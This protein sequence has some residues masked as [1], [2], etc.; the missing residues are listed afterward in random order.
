MPHRGDGNGPL[1]R[2]WTIRAGW[3]REG[4]RALDPGLVAGRKGPACQHADRQGLPRGNSVSGVCCAF[5]PGILRRTPATVLA[6]QQSPRLKPAEYDGI[7]N[8][9]PPHTVSKHSSQ[10]CSH[11]GGSNESASTE[12]SK[13]LHGRRGNASHSA[14]HISSV[15]SQQLFRQPC[16]DH[17]RPAG[18]RRI[19]KPSLQITASPFPA[20][21]TSRPAVRAQQS[22]DQSYWLSCRDWN[23]KIALSCDS[24]SPEASFCSS[25]ALVW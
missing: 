3:D 7:R 23:S 8:C 16:F 22:P 9:P 20:V 1:S 11:N 10:Y 2:S 6:S 24:N 19:W 5:L 4:H 14:D 13:F 12:L 18:R 17:L 25:K 21:C 15:H